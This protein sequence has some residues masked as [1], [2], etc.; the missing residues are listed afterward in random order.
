MHATTTRPK[1]VVTA[2]GGRAWV[3]HAGSLLLALSGYPTGTRVIVRREGPHAGAHLDAFEER[4]GWRYTAFATEHSRRATCPPR[5]TPPRARPGGGPHPHR[6]G[7]R[8]GPLPVPHGG[9]PQ[10]GSRERRL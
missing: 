5:C 8:P 9:A 1:I 6:E 7:H 2:N 3:S 10:A 4:D